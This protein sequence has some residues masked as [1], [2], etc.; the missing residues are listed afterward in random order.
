METGRV[1]AVT[2]TEGV[3]VWTKGSP[4]STAQFRDHFANPMAI[5]SGSEG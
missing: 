2:A 1:E 5:F 3:Q 4:K